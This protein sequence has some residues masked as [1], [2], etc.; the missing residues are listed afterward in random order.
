MIESLRSFGGEGCGT[1]VWIATILC[2]CW[3]V[4]C[5]ATAP[6]PPVPAAFSSNTPL[7]SSSLV[8]DSTENPRP[9]D[10]AGR[11]YP[12]PE[13]PAIRGKQDDIYFLDA[14]TG[15]SVNGLGNIY[16]TDD[17]GATWEHLLHQEGTYFRAIAFLDAEV[18]FAGNIGT[19]Y[20]PGV[21]DTTALYRTRDGGQTW[22]PVTEINGVYPKGIC[23]LE[24]VDETTLFGTGR[25]G[26]PSFL[27]VSRD[28][29]ETWTS[30]DLSDQVA[31]LIDAEF[32]SPERGFLIGGSSTDLAQSHT[33]ILATE[34]G[35][36]TWTE[37]FRSAQPMELG[38]KLDFPTPEVGYAS[39]MAYDSS[40]TVVKTRD[41]G[42][43]WTELSLLDA[44]Y[45]AKGVGFV[46]AA[47][48][49]VGGE[50]PGQPAYFTSDGG[51]SW[52]PDTSLG[53]LINR[54][55][56]IRGLGSRLAA[57][58][59]IG[60]TIHKLKLGERHGIDLGWKEGPPLPVPRDHHAT[61]LL[62]TPEAA[63]L[64][65]A[66]GNTY[67]SIIGDVWCAGLL[68]DGGLAPWAP[69]HPLPDPQAG[70]GLVVT[71]RSVLLIG[72]KDST[73]EPTARVLA[74]AVTASGEIGP[75]VEAP[76]LPQPLFHL[77]A[78]YAGGNVYVIG[79]NRGE[80]G[81]RTVFR[82]PLRADG[83]IGAWVAD[84]PLPRPRSHHASFVHGG[85][86]Y[87]VGGLDGNPAGENTPLRDV[88]RSTVAPDGTLLPWTTVSELDSAY[89][90]HAAFVHGDHA[91]LVGGV[92][93]DARLSDAV[94]HAPFR[95]DGSV[96]LWKRLPQRLPF[97]RAHVHHLP[98]WRSRVYSVGGRTGTRITGATYTGILDR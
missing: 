60:M 47:T 28:A 84:R 21:T 89:A 98:Q 35:G 43:T 50:R 45:Q 6:S 36:R 20:Y 93:N 70:M 82:A 66:G 48:G 72:G 77:T 73:F 52:R 63:R 5:G 91:Y 54:F 94:L 16:K 65:V 22:A 38:W 13:A 23:N 74:A 33:L 24:I 86:L 75:W 4:G 27:I 53:P 78:E 55:R 62:T 58:Y 41:G 92:E 69:D 3:L 32:V 34:D 44:P 8:P 85:A 71:D 56:F 30:R 17:G 2:A 95:A 57:G 19:D 76:A 79:G 61:F 26:G 1:E 68:P 39:V 67:T 37:A 96:G 10:L 46:D 18:G 51:L 49:W 88:L 29:G 25:V 83:S 31:M 15:W 64:C 42:R 9:T 59:A 81:S 40:A 11:W 12:L 7:A 90:A 14:E 80:E 87:V 97:A